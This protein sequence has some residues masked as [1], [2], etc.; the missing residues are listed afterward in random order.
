[1]N[2]IKASRSVLYRLTLDAMFLAIYVVFSIGIPSQ[3]SWASL[4][5]LLCAFLLSPGDT[6]AIATI[7]SF[8]EQLTYGLGVTTIFWM[9]PWVAFALCAGLGAAL[10]R[11]RERL[12]KMITVIVVSELLLSLCNSIAL[13]GLGFAIL[14]MSSPWMILLGFVTRM[15]QGVIRAVVSS[16]VIPILLPPVRRVLAKTRPSSTND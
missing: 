8:I 12:W 7:G 16:V 6:V 3:I 11:R 2:R 5:I 15:P 14:D 4:P 13:F 9:L 1:M 10:V